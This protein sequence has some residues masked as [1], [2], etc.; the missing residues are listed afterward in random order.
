MFRRLSSIWNTYTETSTYGFI[1]DRY[2]WKRLNK[3]KNVPIVVKK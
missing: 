3:M 2:E 1:V